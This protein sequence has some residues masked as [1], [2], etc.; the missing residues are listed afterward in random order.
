[1]ICRLV[2][3][4]IALAPGAAAA[5]TTALTLDEVLQSS[6]RSAPQIVESLAKVR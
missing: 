5:Q 2:F 3:L 1:M 6:A 4:L